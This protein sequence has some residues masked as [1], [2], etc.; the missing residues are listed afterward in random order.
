MVSK[1]NRV[2][3]MAFKKREGIA[4]MKRNL[5]FLVVLTIIVSIVGSGMIVFADSGEEFQVLSAVQT[6]EQ[7]PVWFFQRVD[8]SGTYED[9]GY[10][11]WDTHWAAGET[12]NSP[13][14]GG[15]ALTDLNVNAGD[16]WGG[17]YDGV[18]TFL[19][20]YSADAKI[21]PTAGFEKIRL[22]FDG[23]AEVKVPTKVK[24]LHNG[25]K[26]WPSSG[27][28]ADV[29]NGKPIDFPVLNLKVKQDDTIR[30]IVRGDKAN[31]WKNH[32]KVVPT[33]TLTKES[34]A[35]P[36]VEATKTETKAADST[37]A[38]KSN[39]K[40][41]DVSYIVFVAMAVV[42]ALALVMRRKVSA[43]KA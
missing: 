4:R 18:I 28:W 23:D 43:D 3:L 19:A 31:T 22:H 29:E 5:M 34:A 35:A 32:T 40:T 17:P 37:T 8:E 7:G 16:E 30:F 42:S 41:G 39:P 11:V 36:A 26:I 25:K 13:Q 38:A 15:D 27:E 9:L 12:G 21:S 6:K 10:F 33:I 24:I 14:I 2:L 1:G 20:P